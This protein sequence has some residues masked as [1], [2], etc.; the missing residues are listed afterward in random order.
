M[1]EE[2]E[3]TNLHAEFQSS[4]VGLEYLMYASI[5]P[6]WRFLEYTKVCHTGQQRRIIWIFRDL[7][8][9]I[10]ISNEHMSVFGSYFDWCFKEESCRICACFWTLETIFIFFIFIFFGYFLFLQ[11]FTEQKTKKIS[12]YEIFDND[13]P[14]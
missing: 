9:P 3:G 7:E 8:W 5:V 13:N 12:C 6:K 11:K 1:I 4:V 2:K 10:H 14:T